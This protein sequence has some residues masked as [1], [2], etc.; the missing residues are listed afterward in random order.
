M[1]HL[2]H[3]SHG[4]TGAVIRHA[5]QRGYLSSESLQQAIAI[6]ESSSAAGRPEE[7]LSVLRAR[8]LRPE[9]VAE[10][11]AVYRAAAGS[12][13]LPRAD[14]PSGP[15][16]GRVASESDTGAG[17]HGPAG[18]LDSSFTPAEAHR[19]PSGRSG[20]PEEI[21]GYRIVRELARGAFGIV[22]H[23]HSLKLDRPVAIKVMRHAEM[24]TEED[25]ERF[26][27]EARAAAR[28]RHPNIVG[29]HDVGQEGERHYLVMDLID[30]ESLKE[31][32]DRDGPL[33]EDRAAEITER[34]CEAL[35]YA[36]S[37]QILHRD[38]KPANILISTRGE[39]MLTDFGL[40]K[41]A[42]QDGEGL[43]AT[44]QAMGTPAYMPPE[45]AA[46]ALDRIDRRSDVYSL[47]A[48]LY[49][50]LTGRPP[51]SGATALLTMNEV[52]NSDPRPPRSLRAGL[53]RDLETICLKCLEK[54]PEARYDSANLLGEELARFRAGEAIL[55][56]PLSPLGQGRRWL[57]RNPVIAGA[58]LVVALVLGTGG[59]AAYFWKVGIE[60]ERTQQAEARLA[61]IR[62][63]VSSLLDEVE[64][65]QVTRND[66]LLRVFYDLVRRT[67]PEA[68]E[69]MVARLDSV[70]DALFSVSRDTYLA[71]NELSKDEEAAGHARIPNLAVALEALRT[72]R[73]GDSLPASAQAALDQ[74]GKR[75][76]EREYA[77]FKVRLSGR[78]VN[79]KGLIASRQG[80]LANELSVARLLLFVLA[81]LEGDAVVEAFGR[82]L[83]A[84]ADPVRSIPA[85]QALRRQR[86]ARAKELLF[87]GRDLFGT[88]SDFWRTL[89]GG[90]EEDLSGLQEAD[91]P[92]L[93]STAGL[94]YQAELDLERERYRDCAKNASAAIELESRN[95]RAWIL[96]AR[97]HWFLKDYRGALN[98]SREVIKLDP[99]RAFAWIV[100]GQ[101]LEKLGY[102]DQALASFDEAVAKNPTKDWAYR[103]RGA[104]LSTAKNF[105]R[106]LE[107]TAKAVLL[108]RGDWRNW[109]ARALVY[110]RTRR[111][112]A[113]E[114]DYLRAVSLNKNHYQTWLNLSTTRWEL[115]KFRQ[116]EGDATRALRL[117]AGTP[118]LEA[119]VLANRAVYFQSLGNFEAALRD[120]D[121]AIEKAPTVT[122]P[123]ATRGA[124]RGMLGRY[125]EAIADLD[126]AIKLDPKQSDA[127]LNRGLIR[128]QLGA[129]TTALADID[130][131]IR[132]SPELAN[133]Y[134]QRGAIHSRR[135]DLKQ[136]REDFRKALSLSPKD[137]A[138]WHLLGD[139]YARYG[140][141]SNALKALSTGLKYEPD[142]VRL[143]RRRGGLHQALKKIPKALADFTRAL[144][145][146]PQ[147]A[148]I[149]RLRARL[150]AESGR[151][152]EAIEDYTTALRAD[153]THFLTWLSRAT[154][155]HHSGDT[156]AAKRDL[157]QGEKVAGQKAEF[158]QERAMVEAQW[159]D[160]EASL[161][162][163]G[164]ALA[165]GGGKNPR[166]FLLRAELRE[167]A[168]KLEGAIT[169]FERFLQLKPDDEL[170]DQLRARVR[171]LRER[172][173]K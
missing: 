92:D 155:Y 136:A 148:E 144:Q 3:S 142:N 78:R 9:H 26:Q 103:E 141:S 17:S 10:L 124:L 154:V 135:Q 104:V 105:T 160:H 72:L 52:V 14:V 63:E 94:L 159:G 81:R 49:E 140:D 80:R 126:R 122:A 21:A 99:E 69:V 86:S 116:A 114:A 13:P 59:V 47:G 150:Y 93:E 166:L 73:P 164:K 167:G 162:S 101:S 37:N 76:E 70:S 45:Q 54:E 123:W 8:F 23:A 48:T 1:S 4:P 39:P 56:R 29:I 145:I 60:Q 88:E 120:L 55:A 169:D 83:L 108:G 40:A 170:A 143:L 111:F 89:K 51:F 53:S 64:G 87:W 32:I 113:A 151:L 77:R 117:V 127:W 24:A 132:L 22:Y 11:T 161:A 2:S 25:F 79:I 168:G 46:G 31:Q 85:G 165:M 65:G 107:D 163:V 96:R 57:R 20:A 33:D 90:R 133:P 147:D 95:V 115:K 149:R 36:H 41:D 138:V 118:K 173:E 12:G 98:D 91:E 137:P 125:K 121:G 152:G 71:G 156:A 68:I 35:Y 134:A 129:T 119:R 34:L 146:D 62:Q 128:D 139:H 157:A 100:Q 97:A 28:L 27:I 19:S 74:A 6:Q 58:T 66:D 106:A 109:D 18:H 171:V 38:L 102:A 130:T 30:G 44:G 15:P 67:E 112:S 50:M 16:T 153:P 42:R 61:K 75:V 7:L 43:T 82:Y 5:L 131:A 172:L 158:W 84:E 110:L